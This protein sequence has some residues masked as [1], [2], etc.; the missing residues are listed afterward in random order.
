MTAGL[1][2]LSY[3]VFQWPLWFFCVLPCCV[4]LCCVLLL[5][6]RLC[7]AVLRRWCCTA[8]HHFGLLCL[9]HTSFVCSDNQQDADRS[10]ASHPEVKGSLSLKK[11]P[12]TTFSNKAGEGDSMRCNHTVWSATSTRLSDTVLSWASHKGRII[13]S[14]TS[15]Y[16][17]STCHRF[18]S[19]PVF[20]TFSVCFLCIFAA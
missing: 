8:S 6:A 2:W 12:L 11:E 3:R 5:H 15:H 1:F 14:Y 4:V 20:S 10:T 19:L 18:L 17:S 13:Q 9:P 7:W 16:G